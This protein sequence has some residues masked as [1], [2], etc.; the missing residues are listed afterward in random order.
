MRRRSVRALVTL[1][2][3]AVTLIV[4]QAAECQQTEDPPK[5]GKSCPVGTV[6]KVYRHAG[7]PGNIKCVPD[8]NDNGIP[9]QDE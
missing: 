4:T 8:E 2:A 6:G 9:D 5:P 7:K 1:W 3:V